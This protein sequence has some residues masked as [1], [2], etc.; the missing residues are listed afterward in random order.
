MAVVGTSRPALGDRYE[1]L[2][3][4]MA[5]GNVT[6]KVN[7]V[8]GFSTKMEAL[9]TT[10]KTAMVAAKVGPDRPHREAG[11]RPRIPDDRTR[12]P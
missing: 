9:L 10:N 1:Q 12:R 2:E 6:Y 7:E 5:N 11:T 8:I 3:M 4:I